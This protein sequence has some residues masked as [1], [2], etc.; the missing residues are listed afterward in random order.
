ME[1]ERRRKLIPIL[2]LGV[3]FLIFVGLGITLLP[4]LKALIGGSR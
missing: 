1:L 4:G 2:V 3:I